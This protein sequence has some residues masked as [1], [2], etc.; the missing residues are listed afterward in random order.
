MKNITIRDKDGLFVN[1]NLFVPCVTTDVCISHNLTELRVELEGNNRILRRGTRQV[2]FSFSIKGSTRL[3]RPITVLF[4]T[5][6]GLGEYIILFIIADTCAKS[7]LPPHKI[8]PFEPVR[9]NVTFNSTV[10]RHTSTV[11]ILRT[12]AR[13][14]TYVRIKIENNPYGIKVT[15]PICCNEK[16]LFIV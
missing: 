3:A 4:Y 2:N 13:V 10:T 15:I 9:E 5:D 1:M 7:L 16:L 11:H 6:R 14:Y 8:G 12:D